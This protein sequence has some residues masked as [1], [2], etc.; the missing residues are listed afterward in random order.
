MSKKLIF[1]TFL[2]L[3]F[4]SA[5]LFV[6]KEKNETE[7]AENSKPQPYTVK[8]LPLEKYSIKNLSQTEIPEGKFKIKEEIRKSDNFSS[9]LF[10]FSH[11]PEITDK[12]AKTSTGQINI[13][14]DEGLYP[15]IIM[16]RG[17]INQQTYKTGDGTRNASYFFSDNSF[18]TLAPDFLGYAGSDRES[19]D[20]FETRF[21]TYVLV[22]ALINSL[23]QIP[24]WD[25]ENVFIW[26]HSNGGHIALTVLEITG[27]EI[28]TVLWAPV[29]KPFPYSILYYTDTSDDGGKLIRLKLA[30]FEKDYDTDDYSL[31]FY[32]D[33]INAPIQLNQGTEDKAVPLAWSD[34]LFKRLSN[35]EK[36][37]IYLKHP[38]AD[39]NMRPL[40]D[41]VVLNNLSFFN[42]HIK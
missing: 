8:E 24:K 33:K 31:S 13:P 19:G 7:K 15:L 12:T 23:D 6:L 30:Q 38:G 41:T 21:Q 20:I 40:W 9:F 28:P 3:A 36:E 14:E 5:F 37:I 25:G 2:F 32:L 34:Q 35:L 26:G 18:I 17:Y 10:E 29:S 11:Y 16:L 42:K 1:A 39:H 22:L 4:F 27:K